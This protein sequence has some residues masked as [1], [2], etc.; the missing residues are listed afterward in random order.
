MFLTAA[1]III[2]Y[3]FSEKIDNYCTIAA[4]ARMGS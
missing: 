2:G 3:N 4:A 1:T